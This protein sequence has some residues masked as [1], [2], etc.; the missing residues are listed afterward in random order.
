MPPVTEEDGDQTLTTAL[1]K[2]L[3]ELEALYTESQS[4]LKVADRKI[5][6]LNQEKAW[7]S[8][9]RCHCRVLKAGSWSCW[10][11]L[12]VSFG[13]NRSL[14]LARSFSLPPPPPSH[15]LPSLLTLVPSCLFTPLQ[16]QSQWP[17]TPLNRTHDARHARTCLRTA[18]P[19]PCPCP[20]LCQPT[21]HR[22]SLK[23]T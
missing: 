5:I 18:L 13:L 1:G 4:M 12:S 8:A 14:S 19:C 17:T 16:R 15:C 3:E 7:V 2:R 22:P 21:N 23:G 9:C 20:S 6:T 11:F 10:T